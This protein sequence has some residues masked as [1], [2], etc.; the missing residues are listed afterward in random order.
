MALWL[1]AEDP[2]K[3][4]AALVGAGV[5]VTQPPVDGPFGRMFSFFDPDGYLLTIHG[6]PER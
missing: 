1:A 3:L 4:H 5:R 2:D 6:V